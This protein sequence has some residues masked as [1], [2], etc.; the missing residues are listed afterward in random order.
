[1]STFRQH[2]DLA[3]ERFQIAEE[4]FKDEKS[5]TAAHLFI[6]AAI[7]YHNAICQKFLSKIPI[8]KQ[9][10]DTSYFQD[11]AEFLGQDFQKYQDAY[12]FLMA[13]KSQADYGVE[14]S[15]NTAKQIKRKASTIKEIAE[16]LL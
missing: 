14:L 10:S 12:E 5:H 15:I 11:L 3:S 4:H 8:H 7:N 2:A 13:H 9:H 1:M 6:N 16:S